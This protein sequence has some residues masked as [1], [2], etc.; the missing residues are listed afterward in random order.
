MLVD[1]RFDELAAMSPEA[2][3]GALVLALRE[4]IYNKHNVLL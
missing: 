2:F 1:L 3:V 4:I